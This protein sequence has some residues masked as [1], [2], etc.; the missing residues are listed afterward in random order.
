MVRLISKIARWSVGSLLIALL[1]WVV[2]G[3]I[4]ANQKRKAARVQLEKIVEARLDNLPT[5]NDDALKLIELSAPLGMSLGG[6]IQIHPIDNYLTNQINFVVSSEKQPRLR[7][8]QNSSGTYFKETL[9]TSDDTL[10]PLPDEISEFLD[11]NKSSIRTIQAQLANGV[12]PTW[13]FSPEYLKAFLDPN[14]NVLDMPLPSHLNLANLAKILVLQIIYDDQSGNEAAVKEGLNAGW[15]LAESLKNNSTLITPLVRIIIGNY[16]IAIE[17]KLDNIPDKSPAKE[18]S[19]LT[20]SSL[21]QALALEGAL[22]YKV[23]EYI[24]AAPVFATL[25]IGLP[26]LDLSDTRDSW[27]WLNILRPVT[28]PYLILSGVNTWELFTEG[29]ERIRSVSICEYDDEIATKVYQEIPWWN[30]LGK[31]SLPSF[32][33]QEHRAVYYQLV[34]ELNQH[35][36]SAKRLSQ[37]TGKWPSNLSNLESEICPGETW[38]YKIETDGTLSITLSAESEYLQDLANRRQTSPTLEFRGKALSGGE[39]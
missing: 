22:Q 30:L 15:N 16:M 32:Y 33:N 20:V 4:V 11:E 19:Q 21:Q 6:G 28:R 37:E 14:I 13:G 17:R 7:D 36:L 24:A 26:N 3:N 29:F 8:I 2:I 27:D 10:A 39:Q 31:I 38:L 5:Y 35:I 34:A 18:F 23:A 12:Q 25:T 9:F 1:L